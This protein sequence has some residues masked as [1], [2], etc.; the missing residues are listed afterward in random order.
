MAVFMYYQELYHTWHR[1][2]VPGFNRSIQLAAGEFVT[3]ER[4]LEALARR[5]PSDWEHKGPSWINSETY[6]IAATVTPP[7]P[8]YAQRRLMLQTLLAE[9]FKLAI[10]REQKE[11][12]VYALVVGT[13]GSKLREAEEPNSPNTTNDKAGTH[14]RGK[15]SALALAGYLAAHMGQ[16]V[17]NETGLKGT[18]DI[19]L[20]FTLDD[21]PQTGDESAPSV[22]TAVK[23]QLGLKLEARKA[24]VEIVVIDH[25]EKPTDN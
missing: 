8:Q 9:R 2:V 5:A 11:L 21:R 18:F 1:A 17:L 25:V 23:E 16:R 22:F 13:N 20:D 12:P 3:D 4:Y 14:L 19:A 10:H 6:D 7:D 24:P 15:M